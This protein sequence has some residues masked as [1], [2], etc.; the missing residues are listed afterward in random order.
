MMLHIDQSVL[1]HEIEYIRTS[2]E[3]A[4]AETINKQ[5]VYKQKKRNAETFGKT[6]T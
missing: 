2:H 5:F 6:T 1:L 3:I 4:I